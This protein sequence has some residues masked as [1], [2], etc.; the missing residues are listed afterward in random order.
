[1]P[2]IIARKFKPSIKQL[3]PMPCQNPDCGKVFLPAALTSRYCGPECA[4]IMRARRIAV[5]DEARRA[6]TIVGRKIVTCTCVMCGKTYEAEQWGERAP[7]STC[8]RQCRAAQDNAAKRE[9]ARRKKRDKELSDED[10]DMLAEVVW[11]RHARS[12]EPMH[13]SVAIA[14]IRL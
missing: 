2:E 6:R 4:A 13:G 12:H 9:Y 11:Q 1:M 7:R 8:S 5:R 10:L 3:R 14:E